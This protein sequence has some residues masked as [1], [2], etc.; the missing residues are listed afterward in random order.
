MNSIPLTKIEGDTTVGRNAAMGGNVRVGG[1]ALIKHGLR[2][3]GWADLPNI[4]GRNKGLFESIEALKAAYPQPRPGW[5]AMTYATT[6]S[7]ETRAAT[8]TR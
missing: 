1:S 7:G 4:K 6:G 5:W 8:Y 3:E 2:V